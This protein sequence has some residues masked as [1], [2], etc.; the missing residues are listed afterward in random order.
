MIDRRQLLKSLFGCGAAV[1]SG[2]FGSLIPRAVF[3]SESGSSGTG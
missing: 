2:A 1:A 3:A